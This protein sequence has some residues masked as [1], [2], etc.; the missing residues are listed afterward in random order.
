MTIL[1]NVLQLRLGAVL[2]ARCSTS[3]DI[4]FVAGLV[5][6]V[7]DVSGESYPF[8]RRK[9]CSLGLAGSLEE[10]KPV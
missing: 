4:R 2:D 5:R 7:A 1:C 3:C 6:T 9:F 8:V 10:L